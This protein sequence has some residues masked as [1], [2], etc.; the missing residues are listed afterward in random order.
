MRTNPSNCSTFIIHSTEVC[1]ASL[2]MADIPEDVKLEQLLE[3]R[4]Q[5]RE[6]ID[7]LNA[8]N[9]LEPSSSMRKISKYRHPDRCQAKAIRKAEKRPN[10]CTVNG[11]TNDKVAKVSLTGIMEDEKSAQPSCSGVMK[12]P[13]EK[14]HGTWI[15]DIPAT[16]RQNMHQYLFRY[17]SGLSSD[18]TGTENGSKKLSLHSKIDET[19]PKEVPKAGTICTTKV[20]DISTEERM[21]EISLSTLIGSMEDQ[22]RK[23]DINNAI[24]VQTG[25]ILSNSTENNF[26][27]AAEN[28]VPLVPLPP[29]PSPPPSTPLLPPPAPQHQF[30]PS[31]EM[32]LTDDKNILSDKQQSE[33]AEERSKSLSR[34]AEDSGNELNEIDGRNNGDRKDAFLSD[35]DDG[36]DIDLLLEKPIEDAQTGKVIVPEDGEVREK[37]VLA[38]RGTDYFDVLP[39]GWVEVTHS[40]GLPIYLH[41][42]TRVC[43]FSRP[44]FIGPGSVRHHNVPISAIPCLHQRRVL[45]EIEEGAA[46]SAA[47]LQN[48]LSE[49]VSV[50][51]GDGAVEDSALVMARLQAPG[52]K[53]QTAED[54]KERQLDT[55]A[56]HDYAKAVFKFKKIQTYR[57]N[58]WAATRNFHRQ[59]KLAEA[60]RLGK[61]A[62]S[63][64]LSV[65][66]PALPSNVKL[67]TVPALE[68]NLKPQHRGFFLNP[69]GKT[70]V[71]VLHEYV[72]KVLK[73]TI[74]YY[75]SE[76]RNS[77]MPY[78]CTARLKMNLNNRV[79]CA[80]SVK[81]KLMLLQEKQRR[82]QRLQEHGEQ[83]DADF[84]VLGTGCGNSKK[85]SKLDAARNALKVLIPDVEF[86]PEGIARSDKKMK[87]DAES[88]K[89]DAV[90]L[91]DMLPIEDS[92]IFDLSA[93][94]GQPSPYLLLQECLKRNAAYGDTEIKVHSVRVKHQRHQFDM[95]VG[96]HR[97]SVICANK[98]EG[99]QKASQAMLKKLHPN[100]DTWGSLIRLYGH[101][102]QQKQQ[103][104]RKS[105]QSIIK[106]Q[107]N[108]TKESSA[109]EPNNAILEKL[110]MEM[111]KL[112]KSRQSSKAC[113]VPKRP[114]LSAT[115]EP[116]DEIQSAQISAN[117]ATTHPDALSALR[118]D[119]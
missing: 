68:A 6:Q 20:D 81:E 75:F 106:L 94:A 27:I 96:K 12:K 72:Q 37:I 59:R 78:G 97:V 1:D 15:L 103:E 118:I 45:K 83:P 11:C 102:T 32:N 99:K 69:Q 34:P 53:V 84:V 64:E 41:K 90:A 14:D 109:L 30:L 86:D 88:D 33:E 100:L 40:S 66:R 42:S 119:L 65:G 74:N 111:L 2:L 9:P 116:V 49:S 108:R 105:R 95:D 79:L 38:Y 56:L 107:G 47:A 63:I 31:N 19:T 44:Y 82:E 54:F 13:D 60:G 101:G 17:K 113:N 3:L 36:E 87:D 57:F 29:P 16:H 114:K 110:R 92:R 71:S 70:S 4:E 28:L 80:T 93:R 39:E 51:S 85:T 76:T 115:N 25:N 22:T 8:K 18:I 61:N 50:Q 52:T 48:A 23:S 21:E 46:A 73:S 35:E 77:S 67:I 26:S 24:N 5:L 55:Q 91:F 89:E 117:Y 112:S 104:A 62:S 43:T 98:R 10:S 7:Q 58:K